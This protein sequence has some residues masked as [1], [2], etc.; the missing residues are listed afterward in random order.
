[1][2]RLLALGLVAVLA[3]GAHAGGNEGVRI[4]IDFDPPNYVHE[5]YP[6]PYTLVDAYVCLDTLGDG[7]SS[8]SFALLDPAASCPDVIGVA[9][10]TSLFFSM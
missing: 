7:V 6:V 2:S 9:T 5:A 1:M 8:V 10:W 4:Y 3:V